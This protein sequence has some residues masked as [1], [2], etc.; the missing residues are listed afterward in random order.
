MVKNRIIEIDLLRV[1]AIILMVVFHFVYD[2][3]EFLGIDID[4]AS[5]FWF[6]VGKAAA[7]LFIFVSGISSCLGRNSTKRGFTVLGFGMII[8]IATYFF[9]TSEYVRFGILH[10]L[11]VSMLLSYLL[12][13][14][15]KSYLLMIAIASVL[16]G[17]WA[18]SVNV[19]TFL[20]LPFGFMYVGFCTMD[21]YPLFP[22]L[23]VFIVGILTYKTFY[24]NGKSF[25]QSE[26]NFRGIRFISKHSLLIYI[27]HQPILIGAM[28]LCKTFLNK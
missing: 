7:L 1:I 13:K 14:L 26:H 18:N 12:K 22:Y 5:T 8:S 6:S 21:Y 4:Y 2:L 17:V 10:F 24:E 28:L 23:A 27:V 19:A 16:M 3:N 20:L 11:G 25:I 15:S 9:D